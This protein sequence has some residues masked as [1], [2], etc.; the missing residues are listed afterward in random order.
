MGKK[1][2]LITNEISTKSYPSRV[3]DHLHVL[4]SKLVRVELKEPLRYLRQRGE[5]GLF[6][7]VL[8]PIFVFKEALKKI[9]HGQN[10]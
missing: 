6:V 2:V 1:T 9:K 10:E 5:F 7:D 8:L 3:L 4:L